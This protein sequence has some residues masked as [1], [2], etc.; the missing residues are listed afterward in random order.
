MSETRKPELDQIKIP[1]KWVDEDWLLVDDSPTFGEP[2]VHLHMAGDDIELAELRTLDRVGAARL[3][4]W[5]G[6][7]LDRNPDGVR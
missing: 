5:L 4:R 6:R 2:A 3:H 7:W 1:D